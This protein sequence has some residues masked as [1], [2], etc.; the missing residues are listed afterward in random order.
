MNRLSIT[1]A[2]KRIN[3]AVSSEAKQ[4]AWQ[5]WVWLKKVG[6]ESYVKL[7]FGY[8][9]RGLIRELIYFLLNINQ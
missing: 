9:I 5:V 6:G 7:F 1:L 3:R 8:V 2:Y 4:I